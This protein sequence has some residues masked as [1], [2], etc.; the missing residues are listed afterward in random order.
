MVGQNWDES[1]PLPA[2]GLFWFLPSFGVSHGTCHGAFCA[3]GHSGAP[4]L[5]D[6]ASRKPGQGQDIVSGGFE[7]HYLF[8][9]PSCSS[10]SRAAIDILDNDD[11]L[12][13]K[14]VQKG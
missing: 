10:L 3:D 2:A 14:V 6:K 8:L 12:R 5:V 11:I 4:L 9:H 13:A 1:D 7:L